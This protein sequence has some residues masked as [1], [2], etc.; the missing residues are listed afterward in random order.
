MATQL[1]LKVGRD[2]VRTFA[3]GLLAGSFSILTG[4]LIANVLGPLGKGEFSGVQLLYTAVLS[5]TGGISSALTFYLTKGRRPLRS[6]LRSLSRIYVILC[7]VAW[8]LVLGWGAL[9]GFSIGMRVFA[10]VV[11]ACIIISWQPSIYVSFDRIKYLNILNVAL[12]FI[13]LAGTAITLLLWHTGVIGP[14]IA[15]SVGLYVTAAA[16]L[17]FA[18]SVVKQ[19]SVE[20]GPSDLEILNFSGRASLNN[21]ITFLNAR[22]DSILV[23]TF[24][25]VSG[26]GIYS[27]ATGI[28]EFLYSLS[29]AFA[30]A[31]A[32]PIGVSDF[33]VSA[34]FTA[35][36][37]RLNTI[38]VAVVSLALFVLAPLL[39]GKIYGRPFLPAAAPLRILLIG[40]VIFSSVRMLNAFFTYQLGRPI[41]SV[42]LMTA[43]TVI[44]AIGCLVLIPR[45]GLSG[46]ALASTL[47]YLIATFGQCWY[48][49]KITGL[50][51]RSL[52]L[53]TMADFS[54]IYQVATHTARVAMGER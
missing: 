21:I 12:A 27:M 7:V 19:E 1:R 39:I 14:L 40:V 11:P 30:T 53:P 28:A 24:L 8:L 23:I 29:Q 44:Q 51:M 34:T 20:P 52:W 32:R 16:V 18:K 36:A 43:V 48:F 45:F 17:V 47:A 31:I 54:Q 9:R 42:Y 33:S 41:F 22:I 13:T 3:T 49:C 10:V 6:L 38:A 46:A 4:I 50:S 15:W 2:S 5:I 26:F 35:K 37:V 25:G